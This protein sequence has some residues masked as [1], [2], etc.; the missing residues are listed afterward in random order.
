MCTATATAA[1]SSGDGPASDARTSDGAERPGREQICANTY[2]KRV[3][4]D[5][6]EEQCDLAV[7]E[8]SDMEEDVKEEEED[9]DMKPATK[10]VKKEER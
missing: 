10:R 1:S 8:D 2:W 3:D 6:G 9:A 7:K 5:P 4:T